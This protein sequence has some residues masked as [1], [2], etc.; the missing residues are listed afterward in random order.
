MDKRSTGQER[1]EDLVAEALACVAWDG[2]VDVERLA[3]IEFPHD[4]P[5]ARRIIGPIAARMD[6]NPHSDPRFQRTITIRGAVISRR[7]S[8]VCFEC[9]AAV[10]QD[11]IWRIIVP[12]GDVPL[13]SDEFI[14][15]CAL[16]ARNPSFSI[17]L[18]PAGTFTEGL[19]EDL[20]WGD[21]WLSRI[22][23]ALAA[24]SGAWTGDGVMRTQHLARALL[25]ILQARIRP[26]PPVSLAEVGAA[27]L[28]PSE[29]IDAAGVRGLRDAAAVVRGMPG[30]ICFAPARTYRRAGNTFHREPNAVKL[31]EFVINATQRLYE[32]QAFYTA[33]I[34]PAEY[35]A[36]C[37][38]TRAGA[39]E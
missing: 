13:T 18:C 33:V 21:M 17:S 39:F 19:Y 14:L 16:C 9:L 15:C 5:V 28:M 2:I 8:G 37:E 11:T 26:G 6:A 27:L 24:A 29:S 23:D 22:V 32:T 38:N 36:L 20:V 31:L 25:S 1:A 30:N 34:A 4:E 10:R 3:S 7:T 35:K 12:D